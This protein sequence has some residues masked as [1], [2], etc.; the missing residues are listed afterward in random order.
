MKNEPVSISI[1]RSPVRIPTAAKAPRQADRPI[2]IGD[3]FAVLGLEADTTQ[4]P[5]QRQSDNRSLQAGQHDRR[6]FPKSSSFGLPPHQ[7]KTPTPS[8]GRRAPESVPSHAR[9]Q[10]TTD[11]T[12]PKWKRR[13]SAV[14]L[15]IA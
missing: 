3:G 1:L 15:A 2:A 6:A 13:S 9:A 7:I 14:R 10:S 8:V 11:F 4:I 5:P 12:L